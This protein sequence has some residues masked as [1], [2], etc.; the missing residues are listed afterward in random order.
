MIAGLCTCDSRFPASYW[1]KLLPQAIITLNLLRSSRRNPSLSAY[2]AIHGHFDFN[3]TPLAPPGT[4]VIVHHKKRKSFGVKGLDGWYTGPSMDHYRCYEC[5]IP[6]T[7]GKMNAD[8]VEFFPQAVPF[9]NVTA[10]QY[11]RQAATDILA[12]LQSPEQN[13]PSLSYGSALTN[14]YIQVAQILKRATLQ[15]EPKN[16]PAT[17]LPTQITPTAAPPRVPKNL[18]PTPPRVQPKDPAPTPRVAD[19]PPTLPIKKNPLPISKLVQKITTRLHD[20]YFKRKPALPPPY[21]RSRHSHFTRSKLQGF[22]A[23]SVITTPSYHNPTASHVYH[24][25]TGAKQNIDKLLNGHDKLTW[26]TS[27]ANELGRCAQGVGKSRTPSTQVA[28]TNT[29]FFIPKHAVPTGEK[30]TYAN[31]IND[32]RPLKQETHRVRMT[33]GGDRLDC[34]E[35]PSSPAVSLLDTKIMLNSVISDAHKGARYCTSDIKNFYLNNPMKKFRYMKIPLKYIPKEIMDEY[36]IQDIQSNGFVYVEIRKGM[37][38]LKEAGIIAFKRLVEKLAPHG[39]HPCKHTPGLWTHTTRQIMFTLAVD[40]FGIKYFKREDAQHLFNALQENY[41][42]TTDWTGKNYCGLTIDWQYDKG[43]VDISMPNYIVDALQKFQHQ[44]PKHPQH[45]PHKWTTPAYGQKIQYALPPSSLPILDSKGVKRI[46]SI[47]GTFLYYG[48]AVDPCMLPAINEISTQQSHPTT[49][50]NAKA[51]MLMDYAHTYPNATIRYKASDMQLHVDSD[52]AYLVLPKARSRGAGH[53]YLSS[54]TPPGTSIPQPPPNGPI[55]TECV[56]LRNVMTSA[57]EAETGTLHHN[58]IAAIPIRVTLGELNHPQG[59]TYFKTDN[60]TAKGFLTS[61]IRK[62][63]SKA[64]DMKY[65]WMKEKI[66][67]NFFQVY[68]DKGV[69]NQGDYFTKHHPPAHHRRMRPAYVHDPKP[70]LCSSTQSLV[71]GCVNTILSGLQPDIP[72]P[73]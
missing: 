20:P 50:T 64:W 5:F 32:I 56:T 25:I 33:V 18:H 40:D 26:T 45:A 62:K 47:N 19:L 48:R 2:A 51:K 54:T 37:Y 69:N 24:P 14:A 6:S 70:Q 13:I 68:W 16:S 57:A 12:I 3:A 4:K 15:P 1:D 35:D 60:D 43:Y 42:I 34:E 66:K 8:T 23:Q 11:L 65:H 55:L 39:Y 38:G 52:A 9:P 36:N 7:R 22:L 49:D 59:P 10:D 61:T 31:F 28:G 17:T 53:F 29:I 21:M 41:T 71:R 73:A 72:N 30:I 44:P 58:G 63:R 27:L 46:Q 67:D